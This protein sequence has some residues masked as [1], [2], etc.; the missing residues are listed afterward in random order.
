MPTSPSDTTTDESTHSSTTRRRLLTGTVGASAALTGVGLLSGVAAAHFPTQLDFDVQPDNEDDV[1][2]VDEDE[3]VPVAVYPVEYLDGDGERTQFDP[4]AEPVRYRF[5]SRFELADGGG[6]RPVDDGESVTVE[7]DDGEERDALMLEFPVDGTGLE[8]GEE[9][10]WLYWER[11]D[12][13]N[14]GLSGVDPV[15]VYPSIPL[16]GDLLD[17]LRRFLCRDDPR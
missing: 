12:S 2:D 1:I 8:G 3:T 17:F 10:V 15:R 6:T 16:D 13:G 14:H 11:D 9:A 7:T 4:T 5:G